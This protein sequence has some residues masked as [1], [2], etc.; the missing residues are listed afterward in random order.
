MKFY[1]CLKCGHVMMSIN[2]MCDNVTCC[3]KPML[4]LNSKDSDGA[5][6]KHVPVF[7]INNDNL[8][9]IVGEVLHPMEEE[10]FIEFIAYVHGNSIDLVKLDY[11]NEPKAF[12]KY[13]GKGIIYAYC[14][15]H[16]LW[17]NNIE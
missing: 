12:F 17:Q 5:L 16:G 1:K 2:D 14:N 10:H 4:L 7:K 9:V 3:N 13:Q 6:E 15:K 8:E 11:Q